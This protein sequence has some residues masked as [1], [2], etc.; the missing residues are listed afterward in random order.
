MDQPNH[1]NVAYGSVIAVVG[2]DRSPP[3][4][5]WRNALR[6]MLEDRFGPVFQSVFYFVEE[7]VGDGAVNDAVIVAQGDVAHRADGDGV[8]DDDRAFFD[9]AEAEDADVGLAD[10]RQAE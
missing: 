2:A 1:S 3:L 5:G 7:L 8:V 10:D 4:Q 9:G 6:N